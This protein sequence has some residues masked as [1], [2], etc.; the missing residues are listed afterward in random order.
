MTNQ[1]KM[2]WIKQNI[3]GLEKIDPY[4]NRK[5]VDFVKQELL[6]IGAYKDIDSDTTHQA[7]INLI[8]KIKGKYSKVHNA[9]SKQ[10]RKTACYY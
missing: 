4:T 1:Q 9:S 7:V 2:A 5:A 10:K 8:M 3:I 6:R